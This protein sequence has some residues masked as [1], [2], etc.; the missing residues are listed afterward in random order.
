IEEVPRILANEARLAQVMV[1]LLMNAM[2]ALPARP[3]RDNRIV[4][5]ARADSRHVTIE[6][7][8]NGQ[9][10][11]EENLRHIFDPFFTTKPVGEGMGL[12]LS[13][14]NSII[15]AH[16]GRIDVESALGAGSAFRIVLPVASTPATRR[17][18]SL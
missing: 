13:I 9:G 14:C 15:I 4:I 7:R 12:G 1:N 10:I 16:G 2:Q 18:A 5:A 17:R 8:D 6:V 11:S 3:V